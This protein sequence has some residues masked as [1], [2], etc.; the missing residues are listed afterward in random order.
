MGA[1]EGHLGEEGEAWAWEAGQR[2]AYLDRAL[3]WQMGFAGAQDE[4]RER[5]SSRSL[6]L[7]PPAEGWAE[8]GTSGSV[9]FPHLPG[10]VA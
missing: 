7:R 8:G 10:A 1:R 3:P 5:Q 4:Q 2:G 9:F 6:E